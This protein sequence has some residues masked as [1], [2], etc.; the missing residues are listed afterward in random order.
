MNLFYFARENEKY[1]DKPHVSIKI[2]TWCPAGC[3]CEFS[4]KKL[5]NIFLYNKEVIKKNI[6]LVAKN[7]SKDFEIFFVWMN[8]LKYKDLFEILEYCHKNNR[9]F[10]LQIPHNL[11]NDD[12]EVLSKI[13]EIYPWINYSI[14]KTIDSVDDLKNILNEIV[15]LKNI[16]WL[17]KVYFD[18]F[19]DIVKYEKIIK[20]I[21]SKLSTKES[22]NNYNCIIWNSFDIKFHDLSW[23]IDHENKKISNLK[24]KKCL[25]KDYF[26]IKDKKIYLY[27]HVE[28]WANWD[29]TFHDNLCY[30]ANFSISNI[31]FENDLIIKHF[32]DYKTYLDEISNWDLVYNCYTC[33]KNRYSYKK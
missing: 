15:V 18:V 29:L 6:D 1:L 31:S 19:L 22:K 13:G 33:I 12:I 25:M 11:T 26:F 7:F 30:L 28:I 32:F 23:K 4:Y 9:I 14:P 16:Q 27:D 8:L 2:W 21:I 20:I 10:K 5:K 24:R 3:D 17:G